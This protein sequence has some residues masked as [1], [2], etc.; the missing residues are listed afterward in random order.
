MNKGSVNPAFAKSMNI[1]GMGWKYDNDGK[2]VVAFIENPLRVGERVTLR[3][4]DQ[5]THIMDALG[6]NAF[7]MDRKEP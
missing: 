6:M 3:T 2:T 7:G 4:R 1:N 5:V